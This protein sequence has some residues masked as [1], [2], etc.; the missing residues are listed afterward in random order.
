LIGTDF[1]DVALQ[2]LKETFPGVR[3]EHLDI[4]T[5]EPEALARLGQFDFVSIIDVLFHVVDDELYARAFCSLAS[6]LK[7]GG[8]LV[9]TENFLQSAPRGGNAWQILRELG[10]VESAATKAGLHIRSR[11]PWFMLM[12]GPVDSQSFLLKSGWRAIQMVSSR[13]RIAGFML[14]AAMYPAELVL[15]KT[16]SE[17]PTSEIAIA[18]KV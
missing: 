14:G 12:N 1:S 16:F 5:S 2:R 13:S 3:V 10:E 11:A 6:L 15:T 7:P 4:T 17:S 8:A 9:F 18:E